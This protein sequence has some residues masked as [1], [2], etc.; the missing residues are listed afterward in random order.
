MTIGWALLI[1][2]AVYL[3]SSFNPSNPRFRPF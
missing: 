3:C 2:A 1:I